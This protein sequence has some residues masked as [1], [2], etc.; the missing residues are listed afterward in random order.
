MT[1]DQP[2]FFQIIG[3]HF[4]GYPIA[5]ERFDPVHFHSTGRVSNQRM[6]VI[7]LNPI[8]SIR[9]G[10]SDE[11]LELQKFFFGY[12]MI[13]PNERSIPARVT[14]RRVLMK[15]GCA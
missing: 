3:R 15:R 9:Q 5:G 1:K 2:Y 13:P 14:Q 7:E 4:H 11:P 10:L 8:A 12:V 6:A